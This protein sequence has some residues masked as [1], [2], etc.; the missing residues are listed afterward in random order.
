MD[1]GPTPV[2][3]VTGGSRG[4]G[5]AC[6][7]A[8][9]DAPAP[10]VPQPAL[11][12]AAV[13]QAP[14]SALCRWRVVA[15]GLPVHCP[16]AETLAASLVEHQRARFFHLPLDFS[17]P[18]AEEKVE[19][20][21]AFA[22]SLGP[23]LCVVNNAGGHPDFKDVP[24]TSAAEWEELLRINLLSAVFV[25]KAALPHLRAAATLAH[26]TAAAPLA[27]QATG[28]SLAPS[29][30][31][32]VATSTAPPLPM[33]FVPAWSPSIVTMS[34]W[35][36]TVGQKGGSIYTAT[37][38]ALTAFTKSLALENAVHAVRA[39]SI[40]PGVVW[41]PL[42]AEH[43]GLPGATS[44]AEAVATPEDAPAPGGPAAA[45]VKHT[46]TT[47]P[48]GRFGHPHEVAAVAV[49]LA[50]ASFTTGLDYFVTGGA[51]LGSGPKV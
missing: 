33:P 17:A 23:L 31:A 32:S 50:G 25:S 1:L 3:I 24:E 11:S 45:K 41:T 44:L 39:N 27:K 9:L 28:G 15:C 14:V 13:E 6:V 48:L 29:A 38:G 42:Y 5:A 18:D 34:S 2:V 10:C 16:D 21:V 51:E 35:V 43:I 36:G 40:S 12:R 22:A 47:Q 37:K 46:M 20:L 30:P 26:G 49:H 7:R 8:F 19:R 4:I